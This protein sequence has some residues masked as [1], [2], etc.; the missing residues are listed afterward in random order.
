MIMDK[1]GEPSSPG[2]SLNWSSSAPTAY[3]LSSLGRSACRLPLGRILQAQR[4]DSVSA[5]LL[6][7]SVPCAEESKYQPIEYSPKSAMQL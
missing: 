2:L 1:G 4:M 6:K 5:Q 3:W 7:P